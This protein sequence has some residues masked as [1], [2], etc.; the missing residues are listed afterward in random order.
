[1][2]RREQVDEQKLNVKTKNSVNFEN[3]KENQTIKNKNDY[4]TEINT[5]GVTESRKK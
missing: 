2:I 1:M 5:F 4:I 3:C